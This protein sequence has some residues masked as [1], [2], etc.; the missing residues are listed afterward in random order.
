M[1]PDAEAPGPPA[2][3]MDPAAKEM[4]PHSEEIPTCLVDRHPDPRDGAHQ[5]E[6]PIAHRKEQVVS[7]RDCSP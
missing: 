1:D 7:D 2:E 3:E 4:V 5:L 6:D